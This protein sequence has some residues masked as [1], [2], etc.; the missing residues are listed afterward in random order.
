MTATPSSS[1]A[2]MKVSRNCPNGIIGRISIGPWALGSWELEVGSWEF[3][4]KLAF[5]NWE[6]TPWELALGNW[7]L[8]SW[9]L[10]VGS[11]EFAWK[12]AFGNWEFAWKLAFGS[13]E[14]ELGN[15]G[16]HL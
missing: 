12:L 16:V 14:L 6:L 10:E 2:M 15:S 11:W 7:A 5:G 4:W 13:W 1:T 8:G 3:A 9:E